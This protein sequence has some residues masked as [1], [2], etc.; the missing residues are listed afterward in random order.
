MDSMTLTQVKELALIDQ[1]AEKQFL[2]R[3][4]MPSVNTV[5]M[6]VAVLTQCILQQSESISGKFWKE[7]C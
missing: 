2:A 1:L 6:L 7:V 4:F 3:Y 5:I